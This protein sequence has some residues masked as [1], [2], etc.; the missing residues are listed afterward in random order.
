MRVS[1]TSSCATASVV[2]WGTSPQPTA[3]NKTTAS[4]VASYTAADMCGEPAKTMGWWEPHSMHTAVL[5]LKDLAPRTPVYYQAVSSCSGAT[6]RVGRFLVPAG[7]GPHVALAAVLTADMGAT[8]PDHISQ[9]WAE[10]D[11]FLTTGNMARLVDQGFHGHP[12]DLAFCVGDLSYATGY[13]GKWETFMNAVE[14]VSSQVPYVAAQG[15]HEQDWFGTGTIGSGTGPELG[16]DSG[17]ECGGERGSQ[18]P[19]SCCCCCR[20]ALVCAILFRKLSCVT[21]NMLLVLYNYKL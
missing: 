5:N 18:P 14:P 8:T 21:E 10:G 6:S 15:N 9:H 12:I 4:S 20:A 17:G 1:F 13:L 2:R 3:L 11:A 19:K 7:V 16:R